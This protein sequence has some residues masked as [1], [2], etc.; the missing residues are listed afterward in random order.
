VNE[1]IKHPRWVSQHGRD[2]N[3]IVLVSGRSV[4][5]AF[6]DSTGA[7]SVG[8]ERTGHPNGLGQGLTCKVKN[9][10]QFLDCG[11]EPVFT[12]SMRHFVSFK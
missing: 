5:P 10:A 2:E 1:Y 9:W 8:R 12:V 6:T 11:I 7:L 4:G 3:L